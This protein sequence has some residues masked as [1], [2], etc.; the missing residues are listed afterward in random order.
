MNYVPVAGTNSNVFADSEKYVD[1]DE[2]EDDYD[3]MVMPL[4]DFTELP[5]LPMMILLELQIQ[6]KKREMLIQV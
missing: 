6:L 3:Q 5:L 2:P 4:C 1:V